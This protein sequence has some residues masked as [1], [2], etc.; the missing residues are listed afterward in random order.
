LL[1]FLFKKVELIRILFISFSF[2]LNKEI[3]SSFYFW[4]KSS[5]TEFSRKGEIVN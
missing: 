1:R 2:E 4:K 3:F 5:K